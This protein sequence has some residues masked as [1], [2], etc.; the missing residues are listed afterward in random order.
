M[1]NSTL[2]NNFSS[3]HWYDVSKLK[4]EGKG[5]DNTPLFSSRLPIKAQNLVTKA[6]WKQSENSAGLYIKFSTN[7]DSVIIRWTLL[8]K[9]LA[10]PHMAA[11]GV[12]GI[13]LYGRGERGKWIFIGNGRGEHISNEVSF[14]LPQSAEY[15]LYFPLYNGLKELSLG[16]PENKKITQSILSNQKA[17][18]FYGTSSTQ[19]ACASR[20][21][22]A[23]TA[24]VQRTLDIPVIN[25]GFSGAGKMELEMAKLLAEVDASIYVLDCLWNMDIKLIND[26]YKRFVLWL[27][28]AKPS[29]PIL[30]AEDSHYLNKS[31]TKKGVLIREIYNELLSDGIKN[32]YFLSNEDMLGKDGEGTVDGAH[33]ND[34]GM[35]RQASRFSEAI[36]NILMVR[37][38]RRR[39]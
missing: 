36:A 21:G 17:V 11:T 19:G 3:W 29:T 39:L 22:M 9:R 18:V 33:P 2:Q 16:V 8:H 23:F 10:L 14:T 27:H 4:V 25:L 13:D 1:H 32:L 15:M 35:M 7:S 31:P 5:W 6:V 28:T 24:I 12:S 37:I 38:D 30:L 26:R 34:L 20:P